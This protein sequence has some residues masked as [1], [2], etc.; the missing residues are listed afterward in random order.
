MKYVLVLQALN[1]YIKCSSNT[2][3]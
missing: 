1:T 3:L 2:V